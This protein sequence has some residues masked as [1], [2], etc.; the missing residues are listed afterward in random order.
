MFD[1]DDAHLQR[2]ICPRHRDLFG[3]RW[4]SNKTNCTAPSSWCPHPAK[5]VKGERGITL[6]QS[7]QLFQ[8]AGFLLP[9]A[10]RKCIII[11]EIISFSYRKE[12]H[13]L[14][15][16]KGAHECYTL[17]HAYISSRIP[18][19]SFL[20]ETRFGTF[21]WQVKYSG[22]KVIFRFFFQCIESSQHKNP[23]S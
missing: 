7:R 4:R 3:V 12:K 11:I 15:I 16:G 18:L 1:I 5:A 23:K 21:F 19:K 9:V 6:S 20:Q 13:N 2:T 17:A 22:V 8:S 14:Y 10:S